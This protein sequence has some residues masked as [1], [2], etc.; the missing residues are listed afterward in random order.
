LPVGINEV[1]KSPTALGNAISRL[2]MDDTD[3]DRAAIQPI[4]NQIVVY[5]LSVYDGKMKSKYFYRVSA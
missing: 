3:A 5:P 4:L 2:F 1:I